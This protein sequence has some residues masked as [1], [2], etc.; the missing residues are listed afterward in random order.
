MGVVGGLV[1]K[2]DDS[3]SIPLDLNTCIVIHVW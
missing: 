3:R 2:T 1:W